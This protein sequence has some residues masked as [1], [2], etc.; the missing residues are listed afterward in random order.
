MSL[1]WSNPYEVAQD[2][3]ARVAAGAA[4]RGHDTRWERLDPDHVPDGV[5]AL[6]RS[7]F[8]WRGKCVRCGTPITVLG[9]SYHFP[10]GTRVWDKGGPD[11]M[12]TPCLAAHRQEGQ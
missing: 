10:G 11:I 7:P 3:H 9:P 6:A 12:T 4:R 2:T 8:Q 1:D 5:S